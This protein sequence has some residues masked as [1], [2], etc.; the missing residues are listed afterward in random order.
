VTCFGIAWRIPATTSRNVAVAGNGFSGAA[1]A[2]SLVVGELGA[3]LPGGAALALVLAGVPSLA[4]GAESDAG[5]ALDTGD[6]FDAGGGDPP[7]ASNVNAKHP[8]IAAARR[9]MAQA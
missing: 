7:Q 8:T 4:L 1:G 6:A 9:I 3:T 5:V 2:S